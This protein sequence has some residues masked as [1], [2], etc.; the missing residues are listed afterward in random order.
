MDVNI[1]HNDKILEQT[2]TKL[3]SYAKTIEN[4]NEVTKKLDINAILSVTNFEKLKLDIID[5]K[6]LDRLNTLLLRY[7]TLRLKPNE[8]DEMFSDIFFKTEGMV[9]VEIIEYKELSNP[10]KLLFELV[11]IYNI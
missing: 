3:D 8:L 11:V 10:D 7:S 2:K 6:L 9:E 5:S 1:F 4:M